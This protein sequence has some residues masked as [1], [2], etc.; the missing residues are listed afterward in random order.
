MSTSTLYIIF[1][2]IIVISMIISFIV[3]NKTIKP[4]NIKKDYLRKVLI[5]ESI[6]EINNKINNMSNKEIEVFFEK[7]KK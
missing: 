2:S 7:L 5:N 6:Q 3:F 4:I 1:G